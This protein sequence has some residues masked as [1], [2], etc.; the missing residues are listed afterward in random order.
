MCNLISLQSII[1]K[2]GKLSGCVVFIYCGNAFAYCS[3]NTTQ[4][5]IKFGNRSYRNI[6]DVQIEI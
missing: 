6:D 3:R 5:K 2:L 4:E 1:Y